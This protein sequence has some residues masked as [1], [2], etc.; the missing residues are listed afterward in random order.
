MEKGPSEYADN[1]TSPENEVEHFK[2]AKEF[3]LNPYD[4]SESAKRFKENEDEDNL[5]FKKEDGTTYKYNEKTKEFIIISKNGKIVTYFRTSL[6]YFL[7]LFNDLNGKW[8]QGG[9]YEFIQ[10][11]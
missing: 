6:R 4:Y 9:K 10:Q 5:I 7:K 1:W 8:I 3:N 2:H 11:E